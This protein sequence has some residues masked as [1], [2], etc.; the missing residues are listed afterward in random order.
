MQSICTEETEE[1]K[2][3]YANF[4][5][6]ATLDTLELISKICF[7]MVYNYFKVKL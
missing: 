6:N 7:F 5:R 4:T 3:L 2:K 1:E